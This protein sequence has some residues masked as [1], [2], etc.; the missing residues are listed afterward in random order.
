[1]I[2]KNRNKAFE[3]SQK[4][5]DRHS[6]ENL[7]GRWANAL[8]ADYHREVYLWQKKHKVIMP[9]KNEEKGF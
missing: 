2:F 3:R 1:M 8:V 7:G 4:F 6:N 5:H 9:K